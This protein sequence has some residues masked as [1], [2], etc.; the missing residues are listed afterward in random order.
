MDVKKKKKEEERRK[1]E[2]VLSEEGN[3]KA[4]EA[5]KVGEIIKRRG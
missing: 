5:G 4:E 1:K 3:V 2:A